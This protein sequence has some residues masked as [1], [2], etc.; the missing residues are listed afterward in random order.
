M[1]DGGEA[2]TGNLDSVSADGWL[3][4]W[5]FSPVEP[6]RRRE[7]A[8]ELDG[9]EVAVITADQSRPD[10]AQAG[11]GDGAHAFSF[12]L[13]PDAI[14]RAVHSTVSLRDVATARQI[15]QDV[16]VTWQMP[17]R[18]EATSSVVPGVAVLAGTLDRVTRDGWVSGWCWHPD[19]PT[20][21]IDVAI[22]VDEEQ[23]G[24]VRAAQYRPDLE[25][26]GIGD[27]AHGFSFALPWAVLARKGS[28]TVSVREHPSGA[29]LGEPMTLRFG[30]LAQAEERIQDLERQVRVLRA[31]LADSKRERHARDEERAARDLFRTVGMFFQGLA[32]APDE[33]AGPGAAIGLRGAVADIFERFA[34]L[35]L[36]RPANP[37]ATICV[38][39]DAPLELLYGC[40]ADLAAC[41][42]DG[43]ADIVLT[44]DGRRG[45]ATALLPGIIGNLG[46]ARNTGASGRLAARNHV[47]RT[48]RGEAVVFLA[49]GLR[50]T[51]EWL[52][53]LLATLAR[54]PQA[55]L[56]ASPV[57]RD[58]GMLQH[59]GLLAN[60]NGPLFSW[61]DM[62][63]AEDA[64]SPSVVYLQPV[65]A[66]AD[67]AYAV[68]RDAFASAEG[69]FEGF[70]TPAA[71]TID[72]CLRLRLAG[73]E[74][75]VQPKATLRW[76]ESAFGLTSPDFE[77]MRGTPDPDE[78]SEDLALLRERRRQSGSLPLLALGRALAIDTEMPRPD[79]DAGSVA[80][81]EQMG[82]LRKLGYAVTF[83]ASNDPRE[84]ERRP[85]DRMES[86][87]IEVA[88]AP[89]TRSI[90][91]FLEAVGPELNLVH[92]SRHSNATLFLDRVR[93]LAPH[94]RILF[95]PSDLHHLREQ[96][97]RALSG[98]AG[99]SH[100]GDVTRALELDAISAADATILFSDVERDLLARE[101]DPAQLHLLRWT[102]RPMANPPGFAARAGLCF[103]G[104]FRHAPNVD[105]V[106][107]FAAEVM[108]LLLAEDRDLRC[109]IVGEGAPA[110][111][112]ALASPNLILHGWVED[113]ETLLS[114]AR[115][116]I[117]PLRYGAGFKGKVASSLACGTP[118]IG[119]AMAFEGTGLDDG[120]GIRTA[121]D[122]ASFA[123][124][125]LETIGDEPEWVRLSAR[126]IERCEALYSPRA[127][128][129]VY[130][131]VL[132]SLGL[133]RR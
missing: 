118:V 128:R 104:N 5:C 3:V 116:G 88:R 95:S 8:I 64:A 63:F 41:G 68:R 112:R 4:G 65:D 109:H 81:M 90:T 34:P 124:A 61:R 20:R 87:G 84:D 105:A 111:V 113:L 92:I 67:Y 33:A 82:L 130:A 12:Q 106:Q 13:S 78:P 51:P 133:P 37:A 53:G 119:T 6:S 14:G 22:F 32:E 120:D 57:A 66:V 97:E 25:Q 85:I 80:V 7:L 115:L 54:E 123:R 24:E 2:L 29:A 39:A 108:P 23:V 26:A 35:T 28:L 55:V 125:V 89:A 44:D 129:E 103:V 122:A 71:A 10:L 86:R 48:C 27:G 75:L 93:E 40:I 96:R 99:D 60:E 132:A 17:H 83:I 59:F 16:F 19:E 49:S 9:H 15:G 79:R 77:A 18:P 52:P 131:G 11:L 110:A 70:A 38:D 62:A 74:V 69:F 107:W 91:Q 58:D 31:T 94:A 47:G 102:A 43:V 127:A 45:A 56:V 73:G 30:R 1:S 121:D 126:G 21:R 42:V 72:L 100:D 98:R 114:S 76:P 36:M 50:V 101:I 46:Y 117:A